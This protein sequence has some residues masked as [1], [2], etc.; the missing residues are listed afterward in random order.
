MLKISVEEAPEPPIEQTS[1]LEASKLMVPGV[2]SRP[3]SRE[4]A[5]RRG[6]GGGEGGRGEIGGGRGRGEEKGDE[7]GGDG[8]V[9]SDG[10]GG[11]EAPEWLVSLTEKYSVSLTRST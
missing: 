6:G 11:G 4:R 2:S 5:A 1:S 8:G 7:R 10:G 9:E 3:K